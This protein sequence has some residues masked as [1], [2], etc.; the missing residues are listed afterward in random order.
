MHWFAD[1]LPLL[2]LRRSAACLVVAADRPGCS[3]GHQEEEKEV[4]TIFT[5]LL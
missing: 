5:Q 3:Q 2:L 4:H 1:C